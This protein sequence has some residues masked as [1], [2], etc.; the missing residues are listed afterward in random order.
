M[1][2]RPVSKRSNEAPRPEAEVSGRPPRG[3]RLREVA[4]VRGVG[5][6]RTRAS[7]AT[8]G[9][10]FSSEGVSDVKPSA[11]RGGGTPDRS[12]LF[13]SH[14]QRPWF[15]EVMSTSQSYLPVRLRRFDP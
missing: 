2:R 3:G 6:N 9:N 11:I 15:H 13:G 8:L 1:R 10:G 14:G 5:I 7:S 4:P 12:K